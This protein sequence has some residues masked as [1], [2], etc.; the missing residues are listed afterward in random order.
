MARNSLEAS[1]VSDEE[2]RKLTAELD[3][4]LRFR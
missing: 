2:K 1:F 3:D 4:Y